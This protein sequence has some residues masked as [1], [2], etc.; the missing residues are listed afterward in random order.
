[1]LKLS[2][3]KLDIWREEI[4]EFETIGGIDVELEHSLYTIAGWEAKWHK[5]FVSKGGLGHKE[6]IDYIRNFM[7][8]TPDVPKEAWATLGQKE[9]NAISDY[10][11]DPHSAVKI[12]DAEAYVGKRSGRNETMYSEVI[13]CYMFQ[14]GIPLECEHWHLNKLMTLINVCAIKSQPPK[15]MG[16]REAAAMRAKQN[17]ALRQ[18]L[19]SR[20]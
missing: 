11:Q 10:M 6:L 8:Q 15:K 3:P 14:L 12:K 4:E 13:Y 19:G 7:C 5:A 20:G 2:L 1:M 16:K 17:M 18:K 9:F